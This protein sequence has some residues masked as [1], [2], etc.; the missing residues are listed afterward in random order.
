MPA[1]T[2]TLYFKVILLLT[3]CVV[4]FSCPAQSDEILKK[5]ENYRTV[6]KYLAQ[7]TT[8]RQVLIPEGRFVTVF[9]PKV[10]AWLLR[11][12]TIE[13]LEQIR[14]DLAPVLHIPLTEQG[15]AQAADRAMGKNQKIK[16]DTNYDAVWVR[17]SMWIYQAL[18]I[19]RK[20]DARRI[21][22]AIW[23]YYASQAQLA[24]FDDCIA[25]PAHALDPMAVPHIRFNG[26]SPSFADIMVNGKPQTWNHR[27]N[28]AHGLFLLS[29]ADAVCCNLVTN[30]DLSP[31]R[32][33]AL[34][35]F[36]AF[37][38]AIDFSTYE[39]AGAWEEIPRRN[40]S[41][42]GLVTNAMQT[43][44]SLLYEKG[45][46]SNS[47]RFSALFRKQLADMA[48]PLSKAWSEA[49]LSAL[50][51]QGL[52][53]VKRQLSLG[54]ESPDY[55]PDDIHFRR[56]DAALLTLFIPRPL[57]G[58]SEA[59]LRQALT[60]VETLIRP[61]GV[62]RYEND[63]Y[64]SGN[65]WIFPPG[66]DLPSDNLTPTGDTSSQKAFLQRLSRLIP[67]SEAQWFFDSQIAL[68]RLNLA[69]ITSDPV[70]KREDIFLATV[71]LKRALGQLTGRPDGSSPI[72]AEGRA[73]QVM[74]PPESINTVVLKERRELLPSPIT[75]LNWARAAL[76]MALNQ[77]QEQ[78]LR[79]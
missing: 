40:T 24:R 46:S 33:D 16:D 61:A 4:F 49:S 77:F 50:N 54:G 36:P 30:D 11:K 22:L 57:D 10:E 26:S 23:D 39:D 59:E 19:D 14:A 45:D 51:A 69:R 43:W 15:F 3:L 18:K 68:V 28:D 37:F 58:L 9:N 75:P 66:A 41:S 31:A 35:R 72:T 42:I 70:R 56:A 62:L 52:G 1:M 21:L 12:W 65:Y 47:G 38:K 78:G 73:V 8:F 76:I 63:S 20:K 48:P 53:R 17:D 25:N 44:K 64:Q 74:L 55:P 6:Q 32:A 67:D 34:A 27:Q 2:Q 5:Q 60:I 79:H 13:D 7:G 29:L 71:H